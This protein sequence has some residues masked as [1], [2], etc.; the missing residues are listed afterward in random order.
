MSKGGVIV[1]AVARVAGVLLG[2]GVP[3]P[4]EAQWS[5][6]SCKWTVSNYSVS[7]GTLN[8]RGCA[9]W[10]TGPELRWA[11]WADTYVPT[12]YQIYTYAEGADRCGSDPFKIQ[13]REGRTQGTNITYGTSG[14]SEVGP[15]QDCRAG[16]DYRVCGSHWRKRYSGSSWEGKFACVF[17]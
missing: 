14:D 4:A 3:R 12:S 5:G 1:A 13:M 17:F 16:H 9:N 7:G 2:L 8:G 10:W 11:V 15:Y 6:W